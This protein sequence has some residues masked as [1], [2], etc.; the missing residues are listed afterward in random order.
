[1]NGKQVKVLR[2]IAKG[3]SVEPTTYVKNETTKMILLNQ[4]CTRYFYQQLKHQ[5]KRG[6]IV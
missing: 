4:N 1:M 3:L 5:Y 6:F 2:K